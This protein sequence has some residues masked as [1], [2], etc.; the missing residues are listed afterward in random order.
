[1][2]RGK[3]ETEGGR[4]QLSDSMSV[5]YLG[6]EERYGYFGMLERI[7]Q[8]MK[9]LVNKEHGRHQKVSRTHSKGGEKAGCAI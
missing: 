3:V 7:H 2:K 1:M 5:W 9:T 8:K 4:I 6:G